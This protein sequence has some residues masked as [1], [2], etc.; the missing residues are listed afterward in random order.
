MVAPVAS[1]WAVLGLII[2]L[3]A[4]AMHLMVDSLKMN[5]EGIVIIRYIWKKIGEGSVGKWNSLIKQMIIDD[6]IIIFAKCICIGLF[7]E[8][9]IISN[10]R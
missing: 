8:Q 10:V 4:I 2:A 9:I 6:K 5:V 1:G 3:E 7:G